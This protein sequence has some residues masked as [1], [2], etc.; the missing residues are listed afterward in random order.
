MKI[1]LGTYNTGR[2]DSAGR[3]LKKISR[4]NLSTNFGDNLP[5]VF[6]LV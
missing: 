6:V 3:F 2:K 5:T 4:P 1:S